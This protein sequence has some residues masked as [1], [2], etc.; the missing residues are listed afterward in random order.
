MKKTKFLSGV[1]LGLLT[2]S[3][4]AACQ[5]GPAQPSKP[6]EEVIKDGI[7]K[8]TEITSASYDVAFKGDIKDNANQNMKFDV[9][10][11]GALDIKDPKEPKFIFKLNGSGSDQTGNGGAAGLDLK[12]NKEAVYFNVAKLDLKG[13][14][15][16]AL[17]AEI[18]AKFN[19]WW[20]ITLPPEMAQE[21]SKT[22]PAG[23][24]GKLTP[25]QEK[26]QKMLTEANVLGKPTYV[27]V[28]AIKGEQSY[29]Y[30]VTLDKKALV[31]FVKKTAEAEGTTVTA[32]EMKQLED[33]MNKVDLKGDIWVGST[34]GVIT[35]FVGDFKLT[36]GTD[37]PSGT[38]NFKVTLSDVNKPV[39]I[40]APK[41]ATEFPMEEVLGPLMMM[42][43]G[44]LPT[45]TTIPPGG[46]D[47]G[48]VSPTST[49]ATTTDGS[50]GLV[51]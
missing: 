38:M 36:G 40:D 50:A 15:A 6:G 18:T 32:E 23:E 41:D 21:L 7:K 42:Q 16:P 11:S 9:G 10:F 17:P 14:G 44:G 13:A 2:I 48:T 20:K 33:G 47:F 39:T 5:Q 29:H 43:G 3:L 31:A 34:S 27:G 49:E 30:S 51:Q 28:E 4:L 22:V 1:A 24:P 26:M 12:L 19:K 8:L 25:E 45:D 35:Q 37:E 46:G